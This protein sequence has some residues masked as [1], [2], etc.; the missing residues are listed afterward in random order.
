[1]LR[2]F[3]WRLGVEEKRWLRRSDWEGVTGK[4][5][6]VMRKGATKLKVELQLVAEPLQGARKK[7]AWELPRLLGPKI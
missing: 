6:R 7:E 1:M 3:D 4:E 5:S 2:W